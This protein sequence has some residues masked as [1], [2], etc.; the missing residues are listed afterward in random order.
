MK[1]VRRRRDGGYN[2]A[3]EFLSSLY[4]HIMRLF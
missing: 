1:Q 2:V 4:T 3:T